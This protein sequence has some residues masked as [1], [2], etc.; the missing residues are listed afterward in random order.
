MKKELQAD[1]EP[2]KQAV[3][4]WISLVEN[5]IGCAITIRYYNLLDELF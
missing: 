5:E 3:A 2:N 1:M 4:V